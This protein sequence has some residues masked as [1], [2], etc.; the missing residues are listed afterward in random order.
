MIRSF[1]ILV[2]SLLVY[3]TSLGQ[4]HLPQPI[5]QPL[6]STLPYNS[7]TLK[8]PARFFND[9]S[10]DDETPTEL[11]RYSYSTNPDDTIRIYTCESPTQNIFEVFVFDEEGAYDFCTDIL[12][13]EHHYCDSLSIS[14]TDTLSPSLYAFDRH[15]PTLPDSNFLTCLNAEELVIYGYDDGDTNNQMVQYS[16]SSNVEDSVRCF[17]CQDVGQYQIAVYATDTAGNQIHV[18]LI[19]FVVANAGCDQVLDTMQPV[20][21]CKENA[22]FTLDS[23][24]RAVVYPTDLNEGS[25]DNVTEA[26]DLE[27][28]F[29]EFWED[30][31]VFTCED[32]GTQTISIFVS[33]ESFNAALCSTNIVISDP[34]D[35]C[36]IS[37]ITNSAASRLITLY[38][39]PGN[40]FYLKSG[41]N[42]IP[43]LLTLKVYNLLGN[44]VC[45]KEI[46]ALN[47]FIIPDIPP[48]MYSMILQSENAKSYQFKWVKVQK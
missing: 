15:I 44:L 26:D 5:C 2:L 28:Y 8:V 9:G 16:F 21:I 45:T 46:S 7:D 33:D 37:S 25:Y 3:T 29:Q 47:E 31:I 17:S 20:A 27:Y 22:T 19:L 35:Y 23:N 42:L 40:G 38:P 32:L 4:N 11:L 18:P 48:G 6:I 43:E 12:L 14:L 30:S 10:F 36:K 24:K 39:N 13:L 34:D 1:Q 41:S